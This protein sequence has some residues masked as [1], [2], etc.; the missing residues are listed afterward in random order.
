MSSAPPRRLWMLQGT[1]ISASFAALYD[2]GE[3]GPVPEVITE[4]N[5]TYS[6]SRADLLTLNSLQARAFAQATEEVAAYFSTRPNSCDVSELTCFQNVFREL[7]SRA[8]RRPLTDSE[9][10]RLRD[11]YESGALVS[12]E[13]G[14]RFAMLALL[15]APQFLFR[16]E[17]GEETETEAYELTPH[18]IA[19]QLA[20]T[21]WNE[22]PDET[23]TQLANS[24]DL[25]NPEEVRRQVT[26]MVE[27]PRTSRLIGGFL[28]E[29]TGVSG[30]TERESLVRRLVP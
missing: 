11:V 21:L 19:S 14:V 18:E 25:S 10:L 16:T 8:W 6:G 29:W 17:L 3:N 1:Q 15:Q 5:R 23:L 26:R 13:D 12:A 30:L 22:P 9:I 4:G 27:D 20:F 28:E 2:D 24:G 7:G